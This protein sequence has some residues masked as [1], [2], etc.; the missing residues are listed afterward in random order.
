MGKKQ[1]AEA[2]LDGVVDRAIGRSRARL[3]RALKPLK[4]K[5]TSTQ[6]E[7]LSVLI[8]AGMGAGAEVYKAGLRKKLD[9]FLP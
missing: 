1:E 6:L 8:D 2:M 4:E 3:R 5:L 7:Q 9:D